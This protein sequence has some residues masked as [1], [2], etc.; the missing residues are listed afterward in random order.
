MYR[1]MIGKVDEDNFLNKILISDYTWCSFNDPQTKCQS[2][3]EKQKHHQGR[4]NCWIMH[5]Y[6][7]FVYQCL[8]LLVFVITLLPN[9]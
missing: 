6:F 2:S 3:N 5:I 4:K 8:A 9:M 7:I 1:D